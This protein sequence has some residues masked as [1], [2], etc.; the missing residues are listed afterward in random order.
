MAAMRL[1]TKVLNL[2]ELLFIYCRTELESVQKMVSLSL[3]SSS[4]LRKV[5]SSTPTTAATN[6]MR[7]IIIGLIGATLD[8]AT[9]KEQCIFPVTLTDRMY[10]TAP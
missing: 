4:R 3:R 1:A 8:L 2:L 6:S 9:I 7:G 10:I 5:V